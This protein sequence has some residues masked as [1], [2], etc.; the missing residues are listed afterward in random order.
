MSGE[1]W[2]GE[3]TMSSHTSCLMAEGLM[4]GSLS[5]CELPVGA[6]SGGAGNVGVLA[7]PLA[8]GWQEAGGEA[9]LDLLLGNTLWL[10]GAMVKWLLGSMCGCVVRVVMALRDCEDRGTEMGTWPESIM[11]LTCTW[12]PVSLPLTLMALLLGKEAVVMV[13]LVAG[14]WCL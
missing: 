12:P 9:M 7:L 2:G 5:A 1:A 14:A 10:L 13:T 8:L 4:T 6:G 3:P 11:L